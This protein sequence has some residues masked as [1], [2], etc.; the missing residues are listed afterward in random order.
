MVINERVLPCYASCVW[1]REKAVGM[2]VK[3]YSVTLPSPL[4]QN[5]EPLQRKSTDQRS[6]QE[7]LPVLTLGHGVGA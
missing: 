5:T 2:A 1:R 6:V 4:G 3:A 7:T